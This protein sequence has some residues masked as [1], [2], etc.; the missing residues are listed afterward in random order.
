MSSSPRWLDAFLIVVIAALA[1]LL[2]SF[3]ARNADVWMHLVAGRDLVHG[4]PNSDAPA[5]DPQGLSKT[6]LYDVLTYGVFLAL[7]PG[8]LVVAKAL[9]ATALALILLRLSRGQHGL[10][11]AA[12]CTVLA[13][14]ALSTRLLLQPATVSYLLL[15]GAVWWAWR[16][17]Q[18]GPSG[19]Q[20][21]KQRAALLP[22]WPLLVLFIVWANVDGRFVLGLGAVGLIW[23]G[24]ALDAAR[25]GQA[26][27]AG[28]MTRALART[29]AVAA[30]CLLNPHH[31]GA[32]T[33][34]EEVGWF[35]G[36]GRPPIAPLN[37]GYLTAIGMTPAGLAY[38]PLL[39]LGLLSFA[40]NGPR[41]QWQRFLPWAALAALSLTNARA[42]PLFAVV[43]GP[44]LA[45]NLQ[46]FFARGAELTSAAVAGGR[47]L[48]VLR[49]LTIALGLAF[50]IAA[51]PG[52]LHAPPFEPR[53]WTIETAPAL[54]QSAAT[55]R[56]WHDQGKVRPDTRSL[57]LSADTLHAFAWFCPR[58]RGALLA[59]LLATADS[60]AEQQERL[61]EAGVNRLVVYEADRARLLTVL[62]PLVADPAQW[63]LLGLDGDVAVFGWRDPA[64]G[65]GQPGDAFAGWELDIGRLAFHPAQ[66]HQAPRAVP[67]QAETQR[68]WW[69]AFTTPGLPPPIDRDQAILHLT[70]A[71]ALRR[72]A[73]ERRLAA[74][75]G[76]GAAALVGGGAAAAPLDA[77]LRL[78]FLDPR[79]PE[80]GRGLDSLPGPDRF[81]HEVAQQFALHRD[82][83]PPALA[84]LAVR[85]ARRA[86]AVNPRDAQAQLVL[87]E[88]YLR[89]LH[90]TRERVWVQRF[91]EF[92]DLRRVQASAALNQA[93]ALAPNNAQAH[94][95]LFGLFAEM[96]YLD[97]ARDHLRSHVRLIER[98]GPASDEAA[99][100][101]E[102]LSA[103]QSRLRALDND[104]AARSDAY[105]AAAAGVR[106]LDRA[107][108]AVRHGLGGKARDLLLESDIAAFGAQGLA[109]EADLLLRTGRAQAVR[110]WTDPNH[111][112]ALGDFAYHWL[113][114]R[115][116]AAL[117]DYASAHGELVQLKAL[118]GNP[119]APPPRVLAALVAKQVLAEQPV[120]SQVPHL[121]LRGF[122][123]AEFRSHVGHL[124]RQMRQDADANV[125]LGL[126][127]LEQGEPDEATVRFRLALGVWR[128]GAGLDFPGRVVAEGCLPWLE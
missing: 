55:V 60:A 39:A 40:L 104:V 48:V 87:G 69:Q 127:A 124:L 68:A 31:V 78:T 103:L 43:A 110:D 23:I 97:L 107:N 52:W 47:A 128:S 10:W 98:T 15:G 70:H 22:P 120:N 35:V 74:W 57:H 3:P 63:P 94:V 105:A 21:S 90:G 71:E 66:A 50:V 100:F 58:D 7:G 88:S 20:P 46:E 75:R 123:E 86:L 62:T 116:F 102:Q 93:V 18:S 9:V 2:A 30:A 76:S 67:E 44:V 114:G 12:A 4:T 79:F 36:A 84:Y 17:D 95:Q 125:L 51:W 32:F 121:L 37:H 126:L 101:Q 24:Q 54:E 113:R 41:W 42:I 16:A 61:R 6:W 80:A 72:T 1:F 118:A 29:A 11:I 26:S 119:S 85:A 122:R 34:P 64:P 49:G 5:A 99:A 83:V 96:G 91:P 13:V 82:D 112:D 53:R 73:P 111:K 109:L 81:A 92:A 89:L 56:S 27:L 19:Q 25:D 33:W 106:V 59:T 117:G 8:G 108:L 65:P 45:W 77:Q 14:L 38:Y 28:S 115:A